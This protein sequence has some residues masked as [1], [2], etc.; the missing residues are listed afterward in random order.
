MAEK[1]MF[2]NDVIVALKEKGASIAKF[3]TDFDYNDYVEK[4]A[5]KGGY[6]PKKTLQ[7]NFE[8]LIKVLAFGLAKHKI[9]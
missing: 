1:Q 5:K 6:N 4:Y 8:I 3:V 9:S 2:V 7:E